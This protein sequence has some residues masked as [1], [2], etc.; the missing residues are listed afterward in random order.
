MRQPVTKTRC[1]DVSIAVN[2]YTRLILLN[3]I[4]SIPE[5]NSATASQK[6]LTNDTKDHLTCI[7]NDTE[8][9][10]ERAWSFCNRQFL[11]HFRFKDS[12]NPHVK[13]SYVPIV[14][15]ITCIDRPRLAS[16][17]RIHGEHMWV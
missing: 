4:N 7:G 16:S 1:L 12:K 15:G 9:S 17:L 11:H 2:Q 5:S 10:I 6:L 13:L 14:L 3:N 8:A